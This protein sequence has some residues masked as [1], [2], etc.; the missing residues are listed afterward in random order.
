MNIKFLQSELKK[1]EILFSLGKFTQTI[2]KSKKLLEKYPDQVPFINYVGLSYHKLEKYTVAENIFLNGLKL[3]PNEVSFL[4]NLSLIYRAKNNLKT[5]LEYVQQALKLNPNHFISLCNYG[6]LRGDL[7]QFTESLKLYLKA[8]KINNNSEILLI[9]LATTYQYIGQFDESKKTLKELNLKFPKNTYVDQLYSR[10]HHYK[11]ND[12][13]QL[14]MIKKINEFS[15]LNIN[16]IYLYFALTKSYID[17][18]NYKI[19]SHYSK[20]A[21]KLKHQSLINYSF[22]NEENS[23][24]LIKKIFKNYKFSNLNN[25]NSEKLIFI[26]GLP[27]S[28]TTLIHQIIGAHSKVFGAGE[29][30]TISNTFEKLIKDNNFLKLLSNNELFEKKIFYE[31]SSDILKQFKQFNSEK[32]ILDKLPNNFKWIG[33]IKIFFPNSKI[34]HCQ[35]NVKDTALSIYNNMFEGNAIPWAYNENNLLKFIKLYKDLLN[36]WHN[37]TPNF[38]YD[39]NY[40]EITN[41]PNK[42]IREILEF[43]DLKFEDNCLNFHR[44]ISSIKTVSVNQARKPIYKNSVNQSD[45][46]KPYLDFLNKIED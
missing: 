17:Q 3:K 41:N 39:C 1:V 32:V 42:I 10:I 37:K 34:I 25:F 24:N 11:K 36:F 2:N 45:F 21:N 31:I 16:K 43:C 26:V 38:I 33:F 30:N 13:H 29:L 44:K 28:G 5:A 8:Y 4:S 20:I 19:A 12:I 6:N 23:F 9:N 15:D 22:K 35:R 27:R 7:N 14:S 18:K 40:E 46:F